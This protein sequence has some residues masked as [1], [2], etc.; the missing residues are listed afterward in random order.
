MCQVLKVSKSGYYKWKNRKVN[1]EEKAICHLVEL[2]FY[3]HRRRYG[4]RRITEEIRR[5][6][7]I[8]NAKK[9]LRIM[10]KLKLKTICPKRIKKT[11][12]SNHKAEVSKNILNRNFNTE[13]KDQVWLSD[14]TYLKTS[15]GWLYLAVVMDLFS[16]R[17]LGWAL[18]QSLQK[19]LVIDAFKK[20]VSVY[21]VNAGTVFHSDRGVQYTADEFRK[22][23]GVFHIKQSMSRSGNC[24]DNAPMESF[25]HTLKNELLINNK[26]ENRYM[27]RIHVFEY[28]EL[29][30]N[31]KRLH[32]AL[33]YKTPDEVYNSKIIS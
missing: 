17:I 20:A 7:L 18:S 15:E 1:A 29:Y 10:N 27:T 6:G 25:F 22:L 2:I 31:K 19:S 8:I 21:S 14:I 5:K 4:Y 26:L 9:V 24:Y 32:S 30:Y 13:R 16:R 23:L 28:I 33:Q 12:D 11:T 3:E